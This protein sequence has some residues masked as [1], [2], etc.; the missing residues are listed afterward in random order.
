[1]ID[2]NGDELFERERVAVE[3]NHGDTACRGGSQTRI[4]DLD[5]GGPCARLVW[6]IDPC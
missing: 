1:V 3:R 6:V 2:G 5:V 4:V